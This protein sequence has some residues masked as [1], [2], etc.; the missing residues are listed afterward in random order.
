MN[1]RASFLPALSVLLLIGVVALA[2]AENNKCLQLHPRN[3]HYFLFRGKPTVLITSGEHYGAVLNLDFNYV[4]YLDTLAKDGLNLTR[5]FAGAYCEASGAFNIASNTL[6]PS[7]NRFICPWAR[8]D[9]P[10][11]ANGGNKFDLTKWD[12]AYFKRLKD[13]VAKANK[14]GIVVELNLFCPMYDESQ[15]RLSPQNAINNVNGI[16]NVA[17]TN[18]YTLNRNG[19][20]LAVQDAM[21]RRIVTE[22]IGFDNVYYEICNEP[23]FGGVTMEWQH[24]IAEVI[25]E[26]EKGLAGRQTTLDPSQPPSRRSGAMARRECGEGTKT[27][28]PA[29]KL[30]SAVEVGGLA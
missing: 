12:E 21:V 16:G 19:G 24:H 23:Y 28:A 27:S 8:S 26:T 4:K 17:R 18:I 22:L 30:P 6:A 11:Y 15:W 29:R 25:V 7:P 5:T 20:L 13:F 3:P 2:A 1:F 9:R 14:R 10:G